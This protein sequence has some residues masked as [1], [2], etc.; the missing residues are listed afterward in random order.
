MPDSPDLLLFCGGFFGYASEIRHALVA[1]GRRVALF[2]DRP[3]TDSLSKATLRLA[4]SL[5]RAQTERYFDGIIARMRGKPI[6]DVLVVKAEGFSPDTVRRL[7]T[8][9][10]HARFTLYFWDSYGNM[11]ADSRAK[12]ALFDRVLSFDPRDAGQDETLIYRPLFFVDRFAQ[13]PGVVQD[14]DVLFFGTMHGDRF[15]V[16]QRIARALPPSVRFEKFLYFPAKWLFAIHAARYP[17]MLRADRGDFIYT[18][19]S[20]AELLELL[21][22]SRIVVDIERPVQCGYT[23]RTLEALGSGRKL[24]TTNAEVANADFYN[25]DNILVID[26]AAPQIAASYLE[27]PYQPVAADILY[28]YSLSGW[29][30]DVLP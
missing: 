6:R 16:L 30:D 14:I 28:R 27:A 8:A 20:R 10:P 25:P 12:A 11:P 22:R 26:R 17:A 13:L 29:L 18:P 24:I 4:P 1:R 7:R 5:V 3:A 9:F 21:A 23:M 15:P 2:D 19:K